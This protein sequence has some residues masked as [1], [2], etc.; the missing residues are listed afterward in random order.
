MDAR[1]EFPAFRGEQPRGFSS[2]T[3]SVP[4]IR[5]YLDW[6]DVINFIA[7][8]TSGGEVKRSLNPQGFM[9]ILD[10]PNYAQIIKQLPAREL[11]VVLHWMLGYLQLLM[12]QFKQTNGALIQRAIDRLMS[13]REKIDLRRA[14]TRQPKRPREDDADE[15]DHA[16]REAA[17]TF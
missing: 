8:P 17:Q 16:P 13:E 10:M 6:S 12:E 3:T 7:V 2:Q 4:V 5:E 15:V 11:N 9:S 1:T 14:A